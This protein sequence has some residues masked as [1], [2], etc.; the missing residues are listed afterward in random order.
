MGS[1]SEV[2]EGDTGCRNVQTT[3]VLLVQGVNDG[4][5]GHDGGALASIYQTALTIFCFV[6]FCILS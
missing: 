4:R 3:R 5:M 2:L 1:E 6:P